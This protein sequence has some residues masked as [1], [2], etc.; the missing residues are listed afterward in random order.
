MQAQA[1]CERGRSEVRGAAGAGALVA[2][3]AYFL[4]LKRLAPQLLAQLAIIWA[5]IRRYEDVLYEVAGRLWGEAQA[6]REPR[7]R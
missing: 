7:P 1:N 6:C 3:A 5:V 4:P 2:A